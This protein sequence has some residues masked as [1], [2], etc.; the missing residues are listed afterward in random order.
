MAHPYSGY[1]IPA[2]PFEPTRKIELSG[3]FREISENLDCRTFDCLA[4]RPDV[5]FFV[6]DE[7][8]L[9]DEPVFNARASLLFDWEMTRQRGFSTGA[10]I[11]GNVLVTGGADED[12]NTIS[13]PQERL[14]EYASFLSKICN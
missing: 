4:V 7:A 11:F 3:D 8:L 12:G 2:N 9:T 1:L 13:I 6:D 14:D 5:D 10:Q